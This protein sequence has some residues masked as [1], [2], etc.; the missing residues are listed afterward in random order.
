[1]S[2]LENI[3]FTAPYRYKRD[4]EF[5]DSERMAYL[6]DKKYFDNYHGD[7]VNKIKEDIN[8]QAFDKKVEKELTKAYRLYENGEMTNDEFKYIES[9]FDELKKDKE[10]LILNN[11]TFG[12]VPTTR[13]S[14]EKGEPKYKL[15]VMQDKN[16]FTEGLPEG[17]TMMPEDFR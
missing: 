1:M 4:P 10:S 2:M 8:R 11:A 5:R 9:S 3:P 12:V 17:N 6:K 13:E 15:M 16:P 7:Y 14:I